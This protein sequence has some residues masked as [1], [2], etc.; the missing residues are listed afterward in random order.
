LILVSLEL[1]LERSES[2]R[3]REE[4]RGRGRM[5]GARALA[6][7]RLKIGASMCVVSGG[8]GVK[9]RRDIDLAG[10]KSGRDNG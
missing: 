9:G 10:N 4:E 1:E 3:E 6:N 7:M 5:K 2:E 8:D